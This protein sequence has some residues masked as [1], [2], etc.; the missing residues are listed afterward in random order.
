MAERVYPLHSHQLKAIADNMRKCLLVLTDD[1][2]AD[3]L[4]MIRICNHCG[5]DLEMTG[6]FVPCSCM[7]DV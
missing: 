3:V 5:L 1:E 6:K 4:Q 7:G 2:R